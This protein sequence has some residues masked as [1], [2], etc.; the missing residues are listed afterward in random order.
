MTITRPSTKRPPDAL[1]VQ[2]VPWR[3]S[4]QTVGNFDGE[5]K[6]RFEGPNYS[7]ILAV[8]GFILSAAFILSIVAK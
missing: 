4:V 3:G 2:L 6:M 1:V 8:T 5:E 7:Q